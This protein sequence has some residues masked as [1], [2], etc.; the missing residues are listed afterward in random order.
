MTKRSYH[1]M[2]LGAVVLPVLVFTFGGWAVITVDDLPEYAVAGKPIDLS[3]AV[4]QHG[5]KL[6]GD[7]QPSVE[8]SGPGKNPSS[9]LATKAGNH[10]KATMTLPRAGDWTLTVRSGWGNSD[11]SLVPI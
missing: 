6:M 3:F 9:V 10:Y 11:V 5:V 2:L 1:L 4:R 8:L 7:V